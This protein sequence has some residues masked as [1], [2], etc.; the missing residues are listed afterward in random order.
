L[1][2]SGPNTPRNSSRT[3]TKRQNT[4][5]IRRLSEADMSIWRIALKI[6]LKENAVDA[7]TICDFVS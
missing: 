6:G 4:V 7:S 2:E 3:I 1:E 5:P